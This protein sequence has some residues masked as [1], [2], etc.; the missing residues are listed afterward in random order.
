MCQGISLGW[1]TIHVTLG[2]MIQCVE[3]KAREN[4]NLAYVVD[5]E[6]GVGS[7]FLE[8]TI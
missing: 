3:W 2:T 8:L 7:H 4:G 5:M 1:L 6:E